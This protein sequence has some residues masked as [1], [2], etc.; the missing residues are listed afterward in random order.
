MQLPLTHGPRAVSHECVADL[1]IQKEI[2]ETRTRVARILQLRLGI[3][4]LCHRTGRGFMGHAV[5]CM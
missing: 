5:N 3:L 4:L 2:H 1:Q